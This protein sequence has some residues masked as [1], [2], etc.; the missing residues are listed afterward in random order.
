MVVS[1]HIITDCGLIAQTESLTTLLTDHYA[2]SDLGRTIALSEFIGISIGLDSGAKFLYRVQTQILDVVGIQRGLFSA[3]GVFSNRGDAIP[4]HA[5]VIHTRSRNV[6]NAILYT[7]LI[8][9]IA[10]LIPYEFSH[11]CFL[12]LI[13]DNECVV[14]EIFRSKMSAKSTSW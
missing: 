7:G 4:R 3:R 6:Q 12:L 8:K 2:L 5:L 14:I 10:G 9:M 1:I 13:I 11:I